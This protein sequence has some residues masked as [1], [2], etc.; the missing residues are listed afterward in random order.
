MG[1]GE[2]RGEEGD[3]QEAGRCIMV[4]HPAWPLVDSTSSH[5]QCCCKVEGAAWA[6][7]HW[8]KG[9]GAALVTALGPY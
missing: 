5:C 8:R 1:G 6:S 3:C 2:G 4:V 7:D 9:I